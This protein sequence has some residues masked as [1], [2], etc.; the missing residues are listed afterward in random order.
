LSPQCLVL[1]SASGLEDAYER[2]CLVTVS[3]E[4]V[5]HES[6]IPSQT[7]EIDKDSD[8]M[9]RDPY[10]KTYSGHNAARRHK[11]LND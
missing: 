3:A 9:G 1:K 4:C 10:G 7:R 2:A 5:A 11:E 6:L 8:Q